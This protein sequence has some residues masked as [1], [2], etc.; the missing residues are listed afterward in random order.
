M[1][2]KEFVTSSPKSTTTTPTTTMPT[3]TTT[4][5]LR[6]GLTSTPVRA[7]PST[8]AVLNLNINPIPLPTDANMLDANMLNLQAIIDPESSTQ[9]LRQVVIPA[10][11]TD[12]FLEI[13]KM[14][15]ERGIETLGIIIIIIKICK[16]DKIWKEYFYHIPNQVMCYLTIMSPHI[17]VYP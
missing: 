16:I 2:A 7:G 8:V 4:T 5:P 14:N 3:T 13:A 6:T 17:C 1:T 15:S 10:D 11:M 9:E 12:K